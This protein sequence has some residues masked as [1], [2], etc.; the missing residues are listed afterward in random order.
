MKSVF[1]N[2][3]VLLFGKRKIADT[4]FRHLSVHLQ[5]TAIL[6]AVNS[7]FGTIKNDLILNRYLDQQI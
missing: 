1:N 6:V 5:S 3:S 7:L 4:S 2:F